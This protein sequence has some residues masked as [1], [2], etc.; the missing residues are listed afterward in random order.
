MPVFLQ[1]RQRGVRIDTKGLRR[2]LQAALEVMGCPEAELSVV[3][4][5]E[6]RMRELNRTYRAVDESTDV[7]AFEASKET[8]RAAGADYLLGDIAIAPS[9]AARQ[10]RQQGHSL[11]HE[12]LVLAL[13]G[14]LHLLGYDHELYAEHAGAMRRQERR[15][16]RLLTSGDAARHAAKG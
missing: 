15:L 7:L 13:H 16:L 9:V 2:G 10:A 12:L 1:N 8:P 3:C 5:G 6:R 4:I 11:D 14:L